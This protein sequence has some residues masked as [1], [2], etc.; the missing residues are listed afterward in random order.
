MK[1][2]KKLVGEEYFETAKQ[3]MERNGLLPREYERVREN[4]EIGCNSVN[5]TC[6]DPEIVEQCRIFRYSAGRV[7]GM[8][9]SKN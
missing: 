4:C 3:I 6:H 1:A 2:I 8:L 7:L 9:N 5:I